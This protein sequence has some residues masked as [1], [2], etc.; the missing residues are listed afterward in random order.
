MPGEHHL[1]GAYPRGAAGEQP[2]ARV[3][4]RQHGPLGDGHP[5]Q[6]PALEAGAHV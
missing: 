2:V 5:Q 1:T 3:K 6:R 4:S